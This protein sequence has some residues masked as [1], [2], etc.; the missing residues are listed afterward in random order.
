MRGAWGG[1]SSSRLHLPQDPTCTT[2]TEAKSTGPGCLRNCM[3][4]GKLLDLSEPI[5]GGYQSLSAG[6]GQCWADTSGPDLLSV[7]SR[8]DPTQPTTPAEPGWFLHKAKLP[9]PAR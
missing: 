4:L 2:Q 1:V 9:G 6:V 7:T 5:K 3:A 8:W